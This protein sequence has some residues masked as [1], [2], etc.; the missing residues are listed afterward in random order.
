MKELWA[1]KEWPN[2]SL[3]ENSEQINYNN[4]GLTECPWEHR[5]P[6]DKE[7][8]KRDPRNL[9]NTET[10]QLQTENHMGNLQTEHNSGPVIEIQR[11]IRRDQPTNEME[12]RNRD[13]RRAI[14]EYLSNTEN[15]TEQSENNQPEAVQ[16]YHVA[17]ILKEIRNKGNSTARAGEA[18]RKAETAPVQ[19]TVEY[20]ISEYLMETALNLEE[21]TKNQYTSKI[22]K[23]VMFLKSRRQIFYQFTHENIKE[24]VITQGIK[25]KTKISA[26]RHL[27]NKLGSYLNETR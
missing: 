11:D 1:L 26:L 25:W 5:E 9:S 2:R 3:Q 4:D 21:S 6:I 7:T 23:F 19:T 18:I 24:Y 8:N 22:K 17:P 10:E 20:D 15:N 12:R 27:R 14:L 13:K 16:T